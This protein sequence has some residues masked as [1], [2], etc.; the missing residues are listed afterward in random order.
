M[1]RVVILDDYQG[2]ALDMADFSQLHD[3]CK[4]DVVRENVADRDALAAMLKG[5]EIVVGMRERTVFDADMLSR[6]PDLRLLITTGMVNKSFDMTA[7]R[8]QGVTVCGTP[9]GGPVAAEL[10]FGLLLA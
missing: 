3:R 10:A 4:I 6:L 8:A 1:A 2:V 7:A 9:G 5:A